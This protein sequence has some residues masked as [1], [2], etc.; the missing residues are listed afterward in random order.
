[1]KIHLTLVS[2]LLILLSSCRSSP[3]PTTKQLIDALS[4]NEK[5]LRGEALF[6]EGLENWAYYAWANT[7]LSDLTETDSR[8]AYRLLKSWLFMKNIQNPNYDLSRLQ[9]SAI[10]SNNGD[11]WLGTWNGGILRSSLFNGEIFTLVPELPTLVPKTIYRI[12]NTNNTLWFTSFEGLQY[13]NLR[14]NQHNWVQL[15]PKQS[16]VSDYL[17]TQDGLYI[18]SLDQGLWYRGN[19]GVM[20][21]ISPQELGLTVQSLSY[22]NKLGL[23]IGTSQRG[24]FLWK[25]GKL[26]P[27]SLYSPV[28]GQMKNI[29]DIVND[30]RSLWFATNNQG[31]LRWDIQNQ[32]AYQLKSDSPVLNSNRINDLEHSRPWVFYAGDNGSL[33]AYH[34]GRAQWYVW[35]ESRSLEYSEIISISYDKGKLYYAN[36]ISGLVEIQWSRYILAL[37]QKNSL[38]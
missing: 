7:R 35:D 29:K 1:M 6:Q 26:E 25:N 8:E 15:L 9:I 13:Y 2:A 23:V 19:N 20:Q 16:S 27:L 31:L 21:Q 28:L 11:I 18:A 22:D 34:I 32:Q 36:I 4:P 17:E 30:G 10:Y 12:K 24:G 33:G 38:E 3:P 14:N 37:E 5:I